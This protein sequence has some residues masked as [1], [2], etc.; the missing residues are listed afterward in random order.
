MYSIIIINLNNEK[1]WINKIINIDKTRNDCIK[2]IED[3][4]YS[5]K[6]M[7]KELEKYYYNVLKL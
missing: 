7:V 6:N 3:A 1:E 2:Q 4:G 5:I